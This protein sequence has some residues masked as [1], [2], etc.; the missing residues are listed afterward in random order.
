MLDAVDGWDREK[1]VDVADELS[2]CYKYLGT[3]AVDLALFGVQESLHLLWKLD[4]QTAICLHLLVHKFQ[5]HFNL[6]CF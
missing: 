6:I 4:C 3:Y 2:C 1:L 5:D